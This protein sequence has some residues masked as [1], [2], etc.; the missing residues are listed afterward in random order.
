[1]N[2][3]EAADLYVSL[4]W[5]V[6]PLQPGSKRPFDGSRGVKDATDDPDQIDAWHARAP[7]SNIAI[8]CGASDLMVVDLDPRHGCWQ[9]LQSWEAKG[10]QLPL[11]VH[12]RTRSGGLHLYFGLAAPLPDGWR[13]KLPGGVDIQ[14]G[15]KYVVAPPSVIQAAEV[16][17]GHPGVYAWLKPPIGPE[18][19][20]APGW[21]MRLLE[22][23]KRR[24][25]APGK[26]PEGDLSK[27][28]AG[29][30]RKVADA[31]KGTRNDELNK[32]AHLLGRLVV[33]AGLPLSQAESMLI[34]AGLAA[35]PEYGLAGTEATVHSGLRKGMAHANTTGGKSE[36]PVR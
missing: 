9:T 35:N 36:K 17:D 18:L 8:A 32:Q 12:A 34:S 31:P 2:F 20:V 16:D 28:V 21:F 22:P 3:R 5:R 29:C 10:W 15:N 23:P 13:R 24:P 7:D 11:T 33:E 25:Y 6:F 1:M 4:G 26:M 19:P 27:I 14:V 30:L